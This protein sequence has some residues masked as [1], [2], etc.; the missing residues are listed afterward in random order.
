MNF[1]YSKANDF[2]DYYK[3]FHF[4]SLVQKII[5]VPC[6]YC[7][8]DT[9]IKLSGRS[10]FHKKTLPGTSISVQPHQVGAGWQCTYGYAPSLLLHTA[11]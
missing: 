3:N 2:I 7:V 6:I 8:P 5:Q 11:V 9:H 1:L 10:I 4:I